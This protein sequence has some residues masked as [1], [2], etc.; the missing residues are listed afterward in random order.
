MQRDRARETMG[1]PTN[2]CS[3]F[4]KIRIKGRGRRGNHGFPYKFMFSFL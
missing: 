4:Y 3:L 2:S 1:F